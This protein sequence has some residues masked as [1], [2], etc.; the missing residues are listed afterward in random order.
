MLSLSVCLS[1]CLSLTMW[2]DGNLLDPVTAQ[3]WVADQ[4]PHLLKIDV[5]L[6]ENISPSYT[7]HWSLLALCVHVQGKCPG[8][9]VSQHVCWWR[10]LEWGASVK[11]TFEPPLAKTLWMWTWRLVFLY[12]VFVYFWFHALSVVITKSLRSKIVKQVA[13]KHNRTIGQF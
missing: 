6:T 5:A 4:H 9:E 12:F 8:S 2:E 3:L 1:V 11:L 13:Y 10:W 7:S